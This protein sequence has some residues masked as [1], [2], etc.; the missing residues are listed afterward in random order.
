MD[1]IEL[2]NV[3]KYLHTIQRSYPKRSGSCNSRQL[4][5]LVA[6][7]DSKL[8][9]EI[10]TRKYR[11]EEFTVKKRRI[12]RRQFSVNALAEVRCSGKEFCER[13]R[14]FELP[15]DVEIHEVE[16]LDPG[17]VGFEDMSL[18]QSSLNTIGSL[19]REVAERAASWRSVGLRFGQI[20]SPDIS[21]E[22]LYIANVKRE[23]TGT[24]SLM[25]GDRILAIEGIVFDKQTLDVLNRD[26]HMVECGNRSVSVA[27]TTLYEIMTSVLEAWIKKKW[28][29]QQDDRRRSL[30]LTISRC[31][32]KAK[33][34]TSVLESD[35]MPML[36]ALHYGP[37]VGQPQAMKCEPVE[38]LMEIEMIDFL[39]TRSGIG[40]FLTP[41]INGLGARVE[42]LAEG[43]LAQL[44]G[45]L[46]VDDSILYINEKPVMN[47]TF[48]DVL[49]VYRRASTKESDLAALPHSPLH[50][51]RLIVSR[52]V[53]ECSS[54]PQ[55]TSTRSMT[56]PRSSVLLEA[57]KLAA[58]VKEG[59]VEAITSLTSTR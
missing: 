9:E 2:E 47:R 58:D 21:D 4:N 29:N 35:Y 15:H 24:A 13:L 6:I 56:V 22:G 30:C 14:A 16:I 31:T 49:R 59:S 44:D 17:N 23:N 54:T 53:K 5:K 46:Q 27:I 57:A 45:R 38:Q 25:R 32:L 37:R 36:S 20:L 48:K 11:Y 1:D 41:G 40:A 12:K 7:T 33:S 34:V 50:P 55:S 26:A 8:F 18:T 10:V 43:E 3:R 39:K 42:R 52:S 51:I 19:D 28:F